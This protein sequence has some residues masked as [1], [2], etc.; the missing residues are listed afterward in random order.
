M[1]AIYRIFIIAGIPTT[2]ISDYASMVSAYAVDGIYD[3]SLQHT[4]LHAN[5]WL[6][7]DLQ[8]LR[9]VCGVK[10]WNRAVHHHSEHIYNIYIIYIQHTYNM[11]TTY[12]QHVY[13]IGFMLIC[14]SLG[15][16][17]L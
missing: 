12:I 9:Y 10:V 16:I 13:N 17:P 15:Q 11:Y 7:V 3:G 5:P 4:G 1:I 8:V 14:P 2:Q 6:R